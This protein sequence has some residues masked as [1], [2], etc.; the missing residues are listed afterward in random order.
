MTQGGKWPGGK[1]PCGNRPV[2]NLPVGNL[3]NTG[4]GNWPLS[5]QLQLFWLIN[6]F[7]KNVKINEIEF[8]LKKLKY[9]KKKLFKNIIPCENMKNY[10][11]I[12][13]H[14]YLIYL[15][16]LPPKIYQTENC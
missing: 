2:R 4:D 1:L 16:I 15:V 10:N 3:S 7:N 13:E 9:E 11:E 8:N 5:P 12:R 14:D 6:T